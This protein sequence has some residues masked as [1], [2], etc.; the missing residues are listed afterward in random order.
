MEFKSTNPTLG[1]AC[2]L[3]EDI[4]EGNSTDAMISV[5]MIMCNS[6]LFLDIEIPPFWRVRIPA[7]IWKLDVSLAVNQKPQNLWLFQYNIR[8]SICK[9][10]NLF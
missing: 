4:I 7:G 3:T 10:K 1:A 9:G 8:R 6:L 2:I 5:V